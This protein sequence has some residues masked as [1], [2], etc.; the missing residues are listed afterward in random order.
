[1]CCVL[2]VVGFVVV[3]VVVDDV[4]VVVGSE[5]SFSHNFSTRSGNTLLS[6]VKFDAKK[7]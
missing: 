7:K 1:M 2:V 5:V 6:W 4:V 3:V